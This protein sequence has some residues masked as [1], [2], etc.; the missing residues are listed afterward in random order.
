[1][2]FYSSAAQSVPGDVIFAGGVVGQI[3][4]VEA[5]SNCER[6]S[7]TRCSRFLLETRIFSGHGEETSLVEKDFNP[8]F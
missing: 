4:L 8:F 2:S 7:L 1:M 3:C 5:G 6:V